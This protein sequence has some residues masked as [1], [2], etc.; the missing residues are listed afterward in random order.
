MAATNKCLAQNNNSRTEVPATNKRPA[1]RR[2][3]MRRQPASPVAGSALQVVYRPFWR[4]TAR[5]LNMS[6]LY[7][8]AW[9]YGVTALTVFWSALQNKRG[10]FVRQHHGQRRS[11]GVS[12]RR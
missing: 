3:F 9:V 4:A 1:A 6:C 11:F 2:D 7:S 5:K 8:T 12:N 10:A